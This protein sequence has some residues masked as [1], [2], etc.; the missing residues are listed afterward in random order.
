MARLDHFEILS[1]IY[2]RI[3]S[4][5]DPAKLRRFA[6]LPTSGSLLDAGG[7]TG[8]VAQFFFEMASQVIVS[9]LSMGMLKKAHEKSGLQTVCTLNEALPFGN[10]M[11]ARIIVVDVFH[12]VYHQKSTAEEIWRVL[13]PGGRIVIEE[14]NIHMLSV[15]LIA[16][17][18]KLLLMRSHFLTAG[19]IA[20]LFEYPSANISI[21]HDGSNS[22]VIVSK[23]T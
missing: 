5:K 17:F 14:P 15:K 9:D 6:D 16:L 4:P 11:F 13:K 22:W 23:G 18:E 19:E 21:N 3:I 2:D 20:S 12:H 10:E 7:G 8:R 1:P